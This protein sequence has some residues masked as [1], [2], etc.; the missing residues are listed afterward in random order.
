MGN[1]ALAV[2]LG[3]V[4]FGSNYEREGSMTKGREVQH[5]GNQVLAIRQGRVDV[6][7]HYEGEGLMARGREVEKR[8]DAIEDIFLRRDVTTWSVA[9]VS[10]RKERGGTGKERAA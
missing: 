4:D 7:S 3:R 8:E 5:V 9:V 1:H 6:E 10:K 2:R